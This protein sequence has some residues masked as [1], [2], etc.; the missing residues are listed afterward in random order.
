VY[1]GKSLQIVLE[2]VWVPTSARR[3]NRNHKK[4]KNKLGFGGL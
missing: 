2:G 3:R 4:V 1:G